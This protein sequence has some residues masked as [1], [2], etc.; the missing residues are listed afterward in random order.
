MALSQVAEE[1]APIANLRV[2]R[3]QARTH[4][5][6]QKPATHRNQTTPFLVPLSK[7]IQIT[8]NLRFSS[9]T[10]LQLRWHRINFAIN[11]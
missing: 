8:Q 7:Q 6:L 9:T 4:R 10:I 11:L 1:H 2:R 3:D 5:P